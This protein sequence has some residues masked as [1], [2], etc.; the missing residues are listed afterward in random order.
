M[1]CVPI[2]VGQCG[3]QVGSA[4]FELLDGSKE[5][6]QVAIFILFQ[7]GEQLLMAVVLRARF[8]PRDNYITG[9]LV[10]FIEVFIFP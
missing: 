3:N 7:F 1:S 5:P 8:L 10:P 2:F 4:L 9:S 6:M